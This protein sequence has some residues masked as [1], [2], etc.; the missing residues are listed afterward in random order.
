MFVLNEAIAFYCFMVK[1]SSN[2]NPVTMLHLTYCNRGLMDFGNFREKS[3]LSA[4]TGKYKKNLRIPFGKRQVHFSSG[5]TKC[6]WRFPEGIRRF[7]TKITEVHTDIERSV[8]KS[9]RP[10]LS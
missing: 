5:L 1:L 8:L 10:L 4:K 7:I 3:V 9:I 2:F 6:T